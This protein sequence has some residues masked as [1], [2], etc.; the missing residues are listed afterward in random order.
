MH[1]RGTPE[2]MQSKIQYNDVVQDVLD[3]LKKRI[4]FCLTNGLKDSNIIIDPGIGFAKTAE[5]S[6]CL[7]KNISRFKSL[8]FPVLIGA[9]RKSFIEK[10]CQKTIAPAD[11]LGGSL[12]AALH[13]SMEDVDILR[14]HDVAQTVQAITLQKAIHHAIEDL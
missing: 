3:Y 5:Q 6:L 8:G 1:K 2:T 10:T 9:S 12:A 14:V 13:A 11:R 4:D 7:L